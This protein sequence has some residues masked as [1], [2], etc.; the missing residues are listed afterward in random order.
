MARAD[1]NFIHDSTSPVAK[2]V[3]IGSSGC[4][5]DSASNAHSIYPNDSGISGW[6]SLH[7]DSCSTNR[8]PLKLSDSRDFIPS[9]NASEFPPLEH[10]ERI[11]LQPRRANT[12]PVPYEQSWRSFGVHRP[13]ERYTSDPPIG[14]YSHSLQ[15]TKSVRAKVNVKPLFKRLSRDASQSTSLDLSRSS[16][17]YEGLGIYPNFDKG[18]LQGDYYGGSLGRRT[19]SGLHHHRSTSGASQFSAG[20]SGVTK[21]TSHYIHPI[22][23]T[24][25]VYTPL[26]QSY[27]TSSAESDDSGD[28]GRLF[29]DGEPT[30]LS[31]SDGFHSLQRPRLSLQ[32]H[33][34]SFTGLPGMSQT[35]V[36]GR[37]SF[38]YSRDNSGNLDSPSQNSRSSLDFV[39]RP[40]QR[41]NTDP[42]SR[43]ATIQAARK[44]FEEKEAAKARKFEKQQMKAEERQMRRQEKQLSHRTSTDYQTVRTFENA[45]PENDLS[46]KLASPEPDVS[47]PAQSKSPSWRSQ[48]KSRWMLFVTWLQT[49]VFK[50]RRRLRKPH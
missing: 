16:L 33:R 12:D 36:A 35:S 47:S 21:P 43:A 7:D 22:R 5:S 38:G 48:S 20:S 24:P 29:F 41:A 40:K 37:H 18:G 4:A 39:F 6:E 1:L 34:N 30:T 31:G 17:E 32:T 11:S 45:A 50:L 10:R 13:I 49:R 9:L 23:Q 14:S 2:H 15:K 25:S 42:I 19:V 8:P 46:E 27:Q 44:A 26:S 28:A 3:Q